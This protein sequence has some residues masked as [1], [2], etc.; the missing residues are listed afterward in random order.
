MKLSF[1]SLLLSF[2]IC[3]VG[4]VA[5]LSRQC[6]LMGNMY[7]WELDSPKVKIRP[8]HFPAICLFLLSY[9]ISPSLSFIN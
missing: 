9:F 2:S 3:E 8:Y 6:S 5:Y 1:F 4:P 7:T